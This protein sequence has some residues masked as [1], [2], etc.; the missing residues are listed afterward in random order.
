MSVFA[1][2]LIALVAMVI[3]H[4]AATAGMAGWNN[5]DAY[6]IFRSIGR[7]AF[8]IYCFLIVNGCEKSSNPKG[9]LTRLMLFALISQLPFTLAFSRQNYSGFSGQLSLSLSFNSLAVQTAILALLAAGAYFLVL[10]RRRLDK[11]IIV[12]LLFM[13]LP[14][15]KLEFGGLL[16]LADS[17]NVFYTL[18][19]GLALIWLIDAICKQEIYA[20][21]AV[22]CAV[23]LALYFIVLQR[24]ADYSYP[25]I[26]LILGLY[27]ARKRQ[28]FQ[29]IVICLWA[30]YEYGARQG[31]NLFFIAACFVSA[32]LVLLY[33]GRRGKPLKL[34]F[35][36]IYPAHLLLL[37]LYFIVR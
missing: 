34:A 22:L 2:K 7:I 17:L 11:G 4:V 16:L 21:E 23:I 32:V 3:D 1:L 30:V 24:N 36:A 25:G 29:A 18:A 6:F 26:I 33:N 31:G 14:I 10:C 15:A 5:A 28:L 27:L 35:Y 12:V 37:G 20:A 13:L 9:Y 19:A 8:P